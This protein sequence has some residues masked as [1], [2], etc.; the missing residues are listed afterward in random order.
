MHW[1]YSATVPN[2]MYR[3]T[4]VTTAPT[5]LSLRYAR[6]LT[7]FHMHRQQAS[8]EAWDSGTGK[9]EKMNHQTL[10]WSTACS[11][12]QQTWYSTC[13]ANRRFFQRKS[14]TTVTYTDLNKPFSVALKYIGSSH[15][16]CPDTRVKGD[17]TS[18]PVGDF[19][20]EGKSY[21]PWNH[22]RHE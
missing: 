3:Q 20:S 22:K 17:I 5:I 1:F 19:G 21:V 13:H 16:R 8:L 4:M 15:H 14:I 11:K 9:L 18:K 7:V 2:V 10:T 6:Q 12:H